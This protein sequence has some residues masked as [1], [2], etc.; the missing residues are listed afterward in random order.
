MQ[1]L[2]NA[3]TDPSGK[4][5]NASAPIDKAGTAANAS[6]DVNA[7]ENTKQK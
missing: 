4:Q 5:D 7:T 1:E 6:E 3:Y 2:N